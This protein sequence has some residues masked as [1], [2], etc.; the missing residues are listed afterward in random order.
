MTRHK[1]SL[2]P[3]SILAA[4]VPA[5]SGFANAGKAAAQQVPATP[6]PPPAP[7]V[8]QVPAAAPKAEKVAPVIGDISTA[9]AMP[10]SAGKRGNR[11]KYP[12]DKLPAPVQGQNPP[13]FPIIGMTAKNMTSVIH[14]ANKNGKEQAKDEAGNLLWQM[15]DL[16]DA[17]GNVIGQTQAKDGNGKPI[18]EL[19]V[20]KEFRA[21]D[22]DPATDPDKATVRVFRV[23]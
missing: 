18:P 10:T 11:S 17:N 20:V 4:T 23:K 5:I 19:R 9:V 2:A 22:V 16:K 8:P 13:S 1:V 12:F 3:V 21:V 7:A 14:N 15:T 6:V